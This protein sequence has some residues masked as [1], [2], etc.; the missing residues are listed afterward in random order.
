MGASF[1]VQNGGQFWVQN[2]CNFLAPYLKN[3]GGQILGP[4]LGPVLGPKL[5]PVLGPRVRGHFAS[6]GPVLDRRM[7]RGRPAVH[8]HFLEEARPCVPELV[9]GATFGLV[10]GVP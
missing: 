5:G 4:K 9:L 8:Q 10:P 6:R 1:W 7:C 2:G 3:I